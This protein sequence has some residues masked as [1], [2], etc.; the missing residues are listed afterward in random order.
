MKPEPAA[1]SDRATSQA[2]S[3]TISGAM[4]ITPDSGSLVAVALFST[5][6]TK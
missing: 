4:A 1:R 2:A 5:T 6:A 3:M